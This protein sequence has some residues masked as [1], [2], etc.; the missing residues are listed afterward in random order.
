MM[1][2]M[3]LCGI[4]VPNLCFRRTTR[5]AMSEITSDPECKENQSHANCRF[6]PRTSAR[7]EHSE[8]YRCEAICLR[9]I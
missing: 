4:D 9:L 7:S 2:W 1:A 8:N 5:K 6:I 3:S